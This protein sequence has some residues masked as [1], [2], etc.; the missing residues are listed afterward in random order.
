MLNNPIPESST[1]N[2]P[3]LWIGYD[4]ALGRLQ[5]VSPLVYLVYNLDAVKEG[6]LCKAFCAPFVLLLSPAILVGCIDII[7]RYELTFLHRLN[8][9]QRTPSCCCS[10]CCCSSSGCCNSSSTRSVKSTR[11]KHF[12]GLDCCAE[13]SALAGMIT[14]LY[15]TAG[16]RSLSDDTY[17]PVIRYGI[18]EPISRYP[19]I[20][21]QSMKSSPYPSLWR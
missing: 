11:W 18:L 13:F 15:S 7:K 21:I 19:M 3:W 16:I 9:S 12:T 4:K 20:S 1:E 14:Y 17:S 10:C 5:R 8:P 2:L 6:V